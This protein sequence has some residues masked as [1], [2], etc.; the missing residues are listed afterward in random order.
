MA[1]AL[2]GP[3]E[4]ILYVLARSLGHVV[5]D[6]F[7]GN[8]ATDIFASK[9]G[10]QVRPGSLEAGI[11]LAHPVLDRPC[12]VQ[13]EASESFNVAPS[14]RESGF[15]ETAEPCR[16]RIPIVTVAIKNGYRLNGHQP[17]GVW[18]LLEDAHGCRVV[19]NPIVKLRGT[20]RS[21]FHHSHELSDELLIVSF[22]HSCGYHGMRRRGC[23]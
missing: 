5:V 8:T 10:S 3:D 7:L 1:A 9:S 18:V 13:L 12:C 14:T 2:S 20:L 23:F 19:V 21:T 11:Q 6:S 22:E 15:F 4:V 16:C 17:N